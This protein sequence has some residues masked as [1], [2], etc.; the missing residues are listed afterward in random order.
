MVL[1]GYRAAGG[2]AGLGVPLVVVGDAPYATEYKASL[3]GAGGGDAG[4]D[5]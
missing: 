1:E 4:R 5:R 3:A 2:L